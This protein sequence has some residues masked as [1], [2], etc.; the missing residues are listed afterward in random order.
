MKFCVKNNE[1][2]IKALIHN[3]QGLSFSSAQKLLRLG[4]VKLNGKRI[5]DNISLNPNDEIEIYEFKKSK[6]KVEILYQDDNIL[7]INK[8]IFPKK[9]IINGNINFIP[10]K[11]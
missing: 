2:L 10:M 7:I 3:V 11:V 6:P 8:D 4:K 9:R 5:K 1:K